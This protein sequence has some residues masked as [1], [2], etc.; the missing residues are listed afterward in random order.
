MRSTRAFAATAGLCAMTAMAQIATDGTVGARQTFVGANISVP[1]Q[2]GRY[3][4]GNLFHSF[5]LFNVGVGQTVTF[6]PTPISLEAPTLSNIVGRVT[7]GTASLI[8]GTL[9]STAPGVNLYL[10]NPSGIVFG[11]GALVDVNGSFYASSAHYLRS[12]NGTRFESRGPGI[13]LTFTTPD[14]FGFDSVTV[15]PIALQGGTVRAREGATVGIV[16]GGILAGGVATAS[17]LQALGGNAIV[18]AVASPGVVEFGPQGLNVNGFSGMA[19]VL[20]Q[21][22]AV[23]NV[24]EG[25]SRSGGG[26]IFIRGANIALDQATVTARTAFGNGRQVDIDAGGDLTVRQSNVLAVTTGAG[27][28]GRIRIGGRNVVVSNGSLV[29]TS[30]DPGCTT[31]NGGL[32]EVR[33]GDT[34]WI[35]G[36]QAT[37]FVVSNSFGGGRTGEID[38]VAG[39]LAL[40]GAAFLQGIGLR[41][42]DATAIRLHTGDILLSG[43]AQIDASAR[44]GGR[45]GQI[46]ID[47]SGAIRIVGTLRDPA[48]NGLVTPSGI[49]ANTESSGNAGSIVV[50]TR[51]LDILGGGEISSTARRGSRGDGGSIS[52]NA[53]DSIR[54]SGADDTFKPSGIV[55][56]TFASGNAGAIALNAP[57][58]L[59][60]DNAKVQSQSEG[61]GSAGRIVVTGRD[62]RITGRG[63]ISSDA[64]A[65]GDAG[66][67]E[68]HLT[69]TLFISGGNS[70]IF[71]KTYG[72]ARGGNVFVDAAGITLESSG[73][74]FATTDGSGDAGR[75]TVHASDRIAMDSK[76]QIASATSSSG[77]AG[78]LDVRADRRISLTGGAGITTS[79]QGAGNAGSIALRAGEEIALAGASVTSESV[80]RGRAGNI[81]V[82]SGGRVLLREAARVSTSAT[83]SGDAGMV[84]LF[85]RDAVSISSGAK[86][87]SESSGAGFAGN[88]DVR[89]DG[90]L[91][92]TNG[93][94]ITTS[95]SFSDGGD[96]LVEAPFGFMDGGRIATAVGTGQGDGGNIALR[97]P[98]FIL[99]N[100]AISA[101]AFGGD[102][103]NVHIATGKLLKT[104]SSGITASSQLGVDGTITLDSPAIDPT[105]ELLAPPPTFLDAGAI[106]AGRCGP[107][108]AGRA[109]SLVIVPRGA[110]GGLGLD[111][112]TTIDRELRDA[113][114][115]TGSAS[116]ARPQG[117]S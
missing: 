50:S 99:H 8:Q 112:Y 65:T 28:A 64:R 21:R 7:G 100:S 12:T 22:G 84:T 5:Q 19:D 108:L 2:I 40:D 106:L 41:T 29:D 10:I 88:L 47:N 69:G 66:A 103:G 37:T 53:S 42:G 113:W 104:P 98:T 45:G 90:R 91:E 1:S 109:S 13:S 4:N 33:A 86:V 105:G 96:I 52:I 24:N 87:A 76:A 94:Q 80:S 25:A 101:N 14:G 75:V 32:L 9:R 85:G 110:N 43:G 79:T 74:I 77:N 67:V 35:D 49:F 16:G 63:Q 39:S 117:S 111:L 27:N 30:C 81:D 11:Q 17:T 68:V 97:I 58:V 116:C 44:G 83:A 56:N 46:A 70:G 26:T 71:A 78:S 59:I 38:V 102:G 92:V 31:G 3:A 114:Q 62:L 89:S 93:G 82:Q 54:I 15:A 61:A 95:A 20:L 55:T 48:Q 23:I 72:P 51:T 6:L 60:D 73:G 115:T 57:V 34:F 18:V 107:R 36:T